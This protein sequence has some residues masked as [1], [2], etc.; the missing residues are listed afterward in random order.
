MDL[1]FTP[2]FTFQGDL[3]FGDTQ[4]DQIP[5]VRM[6]FHG[7]CARLTAEGKIELVRQLAAH[8]VDLVPDIAPMVES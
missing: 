4:A 1:E 7:A 8:L 2:Y 3:I 5:L 6:S